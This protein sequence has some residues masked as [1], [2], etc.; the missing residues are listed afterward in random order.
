MSAD[1]PGALALEAQDVYVSLGGM[2]V[3]RGVSLDVH[4]GEAVAI[5]GGNGSGKTTFVRALLGLVPHTSGT[6][7]LFG[8]EQEQFV[9][10]WRI[11]YVPQYSAIG[12]P[13][14][15]VREIVTAGRLAHTKPFQWP[16]KRDKAKVAEVLDL[17]GL[18]DR[19]GW[20]FGTLSGGQK[21]RVLIARALATG[22]ELLVMDEP[23]AGVDLHSQAGLAALLHSLVDDGLGLLAVLHELGPMA[24]VLDRSI[25][26]CDGR[27]VPEEAQAFA[28][29]APKPPSSPQVGLEDPLAKVL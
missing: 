14:A 3:L 7:R 18:A 6:I 23:L 2:P 15:T 27:V 21:Q 28:D 22:P 12:V 16:G 8:I 10:H 26:L 19:A 29:C 25:T 9:E 5:L 20:P 1:S 13:S 4:R 11:G 24:A 17:V